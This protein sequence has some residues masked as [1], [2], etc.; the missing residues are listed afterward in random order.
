MIIFKMLIF[1]PSHLDIP[2]Y[3]GG[4]S[5]KTDFWGAD[6]KPKGQDSIPSQW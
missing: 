6:N 5:P 2:G 1:I 4:I 3:T